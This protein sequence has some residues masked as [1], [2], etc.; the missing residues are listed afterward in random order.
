MS[1]S[2]APFHQIFIL[3]MRPG[4]S[5]KRVSDDNFPS[6][7]EDMTDCGRCVNTIGDNVTAVPRVESSI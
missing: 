7:L 5:S 1:L 6:F 3:T 2:N 4:A